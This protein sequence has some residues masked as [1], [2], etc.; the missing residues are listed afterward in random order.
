[1][2]IIGNYC[3]VVAFV[4]SLFV[5]FLSVAGIKKK[6]Q[7]LLKSAENGVAIVFWMLNISVAA[8]IFLLLKSDF[9]IEYVAN[10][11]NRTLPVIY[12]FAAFWGGQD[13]S[14][15][16]WSWFLV[17]FTYILVIQFKNKDFVLLPFVVLIIRF[18]IFSLYLF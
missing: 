13:G 5:I 15:L 8:L 1:M 16:L 6:R 4:I 2:E 14:L 12:K 11:T 18:F 3:L 17:I 7:D 10:Y 9:R